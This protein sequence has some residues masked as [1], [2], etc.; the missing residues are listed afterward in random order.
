MTTSTKQ[1]SCFSR[2][3]PSHL[4]PDAGTRATHTGEKKQQIESLNMAAGGKVA[5][6][7]AANEATRS[8]HT[9]AH[10][11]CPQMNRRAEGVCRVLSLKNPT[12]VRRER[13]GRPV[14]SLLSDGH[15]HQK[16]PLCLSDRRFVSNVHQEA[17]QA[18]SSCK[19]Q[20]CDVH[21]CQVCYL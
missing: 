21:S 6:G 17:N 8:I 19:T 2:Q 3:S 20:T 9:F 7:C 4:G 18:A 16:L 10:T 5:S 11:Q 1:V 12:A 14:S 13:G 15:C